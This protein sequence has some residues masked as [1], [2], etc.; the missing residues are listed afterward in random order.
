MI[1]EYVVM[2]S[3]DLQIKILQALEKSY[4]D[5]RRIELSAQQFKVSA[6]SFILNL[7]YLKHERLIDLSGISNR[8]VNSANLI[9]E[10]DENEIQKTFST[11]A[12]ALITH[13]GIK[14]LAASQ[15]IKLII[16]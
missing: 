5:E 14:A 9:G 4:I 1:K 12:R 10:N 6:E 16:N 7:T 2:L 15:G 3:S 13:A 11:T 8:S